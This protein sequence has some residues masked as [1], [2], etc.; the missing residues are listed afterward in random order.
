M[1]L[2]RALDDVLQ[3]GPVHAEAEGRRVEVDVRDADRL[4]V[5]VDRIR[6]SGPREDVRA[7]AERLP[8]ALAR[9]LGEEL[10]PI[11]VDPGL[12]GAVLRGPVDQG[13]FTEV[14]VDPES[15]TI[16]RHELHEDGR[17]PAPFTLTRE[18]LGRIVDGVG[19][20]GPR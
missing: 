16:R 7:R 11:E 14:S 12:G 19:D 5:T 9:G 3:P 20:A 4:G 6:V 13:R 8:R 2:A 18:Q 10:T 15:V 17:R 1:T